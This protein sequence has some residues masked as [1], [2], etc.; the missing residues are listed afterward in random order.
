MS[1]RNVG[2]SGTNGVGGGIGRLAT[3]VAVD[4]CRMHCMHCEIDE[5]MGR[6]VII[7][8]ASLMPI[9]A[10][11]SYLHHQSSPIMELRR[12]KKERMN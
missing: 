8:C 12:S 6:L 2:T 10:V 7:V 1:V 11:L 4:E 9:F 5:V 3:R